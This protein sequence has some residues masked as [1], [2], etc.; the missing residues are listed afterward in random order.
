VALALEA[1]G[2][3]APLVVVVVAFGC[4]Q[5]GMVGQTFDSSAVAFVASDLPFPVAFAP[6]IVPYVAYMHAL[7]PPPLGLLCVVV[8][9]S[10]GYSHSEIIN[11]GILLNSRFFLWLEIG[12]II[13]RTKGEKFH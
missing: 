6:D 10:R 11:K 8:H 2:M 1:F 3:M 9:H 4:S 7:G 5:M 13:R 12:I